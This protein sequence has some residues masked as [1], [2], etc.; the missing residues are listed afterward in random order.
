M[1]RGVSP[2]GW[3]EAEVG[4]G[5]LL[6]WACLCS[7]PGWFGIQSVLFFFFGGGAGGGRHERVRVFV[8]GVKRRE[9]RVLEGL[10]KTSR[11]RAK[12]HRCVLTALGSSV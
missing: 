3:L 10:G 1:W 12:P 6:P 11:T 8:V 7:L 9:E 5:E 2:G 4:R